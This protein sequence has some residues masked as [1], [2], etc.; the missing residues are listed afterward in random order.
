M[1]TFYS[2]LCFICSFAAIAINLSIYDLPFP[3]DFR[4][5]AYATLRTAEEALKEGN[6]DRAI[7]DFRVAIM[8]ATRC[9]RRGVFERIRTRLATAGYDKCENDPVLA[10]KLLCAYAL[11]SPDFD[12]TSNKIESYV[13]LKSK[14]KVSQFEYPLVIQGGNRTFWLECPKEAPI[15]IYSKLATA[16]ELYK[17][18]G[19]LTYLRAGEL[20]KDYNYSYFY[21]ISLLSPHGFREGQL[22]IRSENQENITLIIG[23]NDRN[24]FYYS[25]DNTMTIGN[26][27]KTFSINPHHD[28]FV[29]NSIVA[30][31]KNIGIKSI[32]VK[33]VRRFKPI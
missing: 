17:L 23:T 15:F 6:A 26:E 28:Y 22:T 1:K 9:G 4:Q 29:L 20:P 2:L 30:F 18:P 5:G 8:R 33:L 10:S 21:P 7:D 32:E 31:S 19:G 24:T 11:L 14:G 13:L 12:N 25:A 16:Q 27:T 3:S